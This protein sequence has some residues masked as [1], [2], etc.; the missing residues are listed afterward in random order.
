[1]G[2]RDGPGEGRPERGPQ[3][4]PRP[5]D[6]SIYDPADQ[7][8]NHASGIHCC[9]RGGKRTTPLMNGYALGNRS[10]AHP[11]IVVGPSMHW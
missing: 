9:F 5:I 1:M 4:A 7:S 11:F 6:T 8:D 3:V 2:A 10:V